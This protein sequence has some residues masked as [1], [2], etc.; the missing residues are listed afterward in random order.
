MLFTRNKV[1]NNYVLHNVLLFYCL[2]FC[3]M[4]FHISLRHV[5]IWQSVEFWVEGGS[6]VAPLRYICYIL[7]S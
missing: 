6:V 5:C 1:L 3:S 7:V 4:L 2:L